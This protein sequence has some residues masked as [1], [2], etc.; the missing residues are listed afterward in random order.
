MKLVLHRIHHRWYTEAEILEALL[1]GGDAFFQ[2]CV[3]L[4]DDGF[5]DLRYVH[6]KKLHHAVVLT[7]Q[8]LQKA[9]LQPER[10][11]CVRSSE[12][13]SRSLRVYLAQQI[14]LCTVKSRDS[15][16]G[17][18]VAVPQLTLEATVVP[19]IMGDTFDFIVVRKEP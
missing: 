6:E 13:D 8:P 19:H 2:R 18:R 1:A 14:A 17:R 15:A 4:L 3:L 11:S 12:N 7:E 9:L 10:G 5:P 16:V